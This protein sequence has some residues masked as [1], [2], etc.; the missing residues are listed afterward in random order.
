MLNLH[1]TIACMDI[2]YISFSLYNS[3]ITFYPEWLNHTSGRFSGFLPT[4]QLFLPTVAP[5]LFRLL[6]GCITKLVTD[7]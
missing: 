4:W 1:L 6:T 5:L 2:F 3:C 7:K